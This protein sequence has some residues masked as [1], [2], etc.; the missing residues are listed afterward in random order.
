MVSKKQVVP[1]DA[2]R[3][4]EAA[5]VE[6]VL[7]DN[8]DSLYRF[9]LRLTRNDTEAQDLAQEAAARALERRHTIMVNPRAWS[10]KR[11]ITRS[12]I[13]IVT[14]NAGERWRSLQKRAFLAPI[15]SQLLSRRRT[16]ESNRVLAG[17]TSRGCMA[18]RCG[19]APSLRG[20][21][22]SGMADRNGRVTTVE[23]AIRTSEVAL[24]L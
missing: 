14:E 22:D 11:F 15:R 7:C 8:L 12:S 2:G 23:R 3:P 19:R 6:D 18:L 5:C 16:F 1:I 13:T 21:A 10:F 24:C 9:A 20:C 4:S 17:G